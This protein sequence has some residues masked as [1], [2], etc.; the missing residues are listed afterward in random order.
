MHIWNLDKIM[1]FHF[2]SKVGLFRKVYLYQI[3]LA[4]FTAKGKLSNIW[5][6]LKKYYPSDKI[7][8]LHFFGYFV[9]FGTVFYPFVWQFASLDI[10]HICTLHKHVITSRR[11]CNLP[12]WFDANVNKQA[13]QTGENIGISPSVSHTLLDKKHVFVLMATYFKSF[14][15]IAKWANG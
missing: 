14:S 3:I 5:L 8:I 12:L 10:L 4:N 7:V 1:N 6:P 13:Y 15:L 11:K 2:Y 9:F